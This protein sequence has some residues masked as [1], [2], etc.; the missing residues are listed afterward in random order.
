MQA[1]PAQDP[2]AVRQADGR[3]G[4]CTAGSRTHIP[5]RVNTAGVI[6]IIFASSLILSRRR[7]R[8]SSTHPW[9]QYVSEALS[10]GHVTYNVLYCA[11]IIFFTYFYTAIV[12]NPIDLADNMKKYGGFIPGI[13]PGKKTAEYIDRVLTRITLPGAIFLAL[14][15]VL[16]DFLIRWF[17]MPVLL[18]RDQ[19]AD[20]GRRGARHAAADRVAPAHAA[21]RGLRGKKAEGARMS[22]AVIFLGP[23]G[24]RQGHPGAAARRGAGAC[25]RSRPAT[26][27]ARRWPRDAAR[28]ARPSGTWTRGAGAGRRGDRARRR[29]PRPGRR[30]ARAS[31]WTAFR[32]RWPRRRRSTRCCGAGGRSSTGWCSSTCRATSWCAGSPGAGSAGSAGPPTTWSRR[33]PKA[34]GRCDQ[35]GGEL[36]QREDDAEATVRTRLEVYADPDRAAARL[37][38]AAA[39]CW[40]EVGGRGRRRRRSAD[41]HPPGG[42][43]STV[44]R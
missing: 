21:L 2:G 15:A 20:R 37:L 9:M 5:L 24:R 1:G 4:G 43:A 23:P 3:A 35:C 12:L 39:A 38:P 30:G 10:P 17:N 27:S 13:R 18:R 22:R 11:L 25:P 26:C 6:P 29:A 44:P 7:S 41:R 19:P 28:A 16:P 32:A 31:C 40:R 42:R 36:N 33:R 14:I 8:A 34:A